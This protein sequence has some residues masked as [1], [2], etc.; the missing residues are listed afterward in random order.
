MTPRS[1][2]TPPCH[3]GI[4]DGWNPGG[5][6]RD[7]WRDESKAIPERGP[8][9][10]DGRRRTGEKQPV[11]SGSGQAIY[12]IDAGVLDA[13]ARRAAGFVC[14]PDST[15]SPK[16]SK[17]W[18]AQG[19]RSTNSHRLC[20]YLLNALGRGKVGREVPLPR[21]SRGSTRRRR[22]CVEPTKGSSKQ[23]VTVDRRFEDPISTWDVPFSRRFSASR[24]L[25]F[26]R[27]QICRD[28]WR[29]N[30]EV[31]AEAKNITFFPSIYRADESK[32]CESIVT[33]ILDELGAIDRWWIVCTIT[34]HS[35]WREIWEIWKNL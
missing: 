22:R 1:L 27:V 5:Y 23:T 34:H 15:V 6:F 24:S 21:P 10:F 17:R 19:S 18:E 2:C 11:A 29:T 16:R 25:L 28:K 7:R 4:R 35:C 20:R 33:L 8:A 3:T 31:A 26:T 9:T 32:N 12:L 30:G 13:D 14:A